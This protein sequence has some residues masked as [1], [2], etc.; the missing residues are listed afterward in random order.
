MNFPIKRSYKY[1]GVTI[2]DNQKIDTTLYAIW[3]KSFMLFKKILP[4]LEPANLFDRNFLFCVF[5]GPYIDQLSVHYAYE[6][7]EK[8][9]LVIQT[10]RRIYKKFASFRDKTP[11]LLVDIFIPIDII[12][13]ISNNLTRIKNKVSYLKGYEFKR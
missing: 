7:K 10:I 9:I 3:N 12:A 6:S 11:N 13:W 8:Q 1:L 4:A 2:Q 5:I